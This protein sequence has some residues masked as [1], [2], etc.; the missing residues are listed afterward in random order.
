M[1]GGNPFGPDVFKHGSDDWAARKAYDEARAARHPAPA[2]SKTPFK[3]QPPSL[4][5]MASGVRG[6][7]SSAGGFGK[8]LAFVIVA[9]GFIAYFGSKSDSPRRT[10]PEDNVGYTRTSDPVPAPARTN[11]AI[12]GSVASGTA[13]TTETAPVDLPNPPGPR[14]PRNDQRVIAALNN[15]RTISGENFFVD[16]SFTALVLQGQRNNQ[17]QISQTS[18]NVAN[19]DLEATTYSDTDNKLTIPCKSES[20]CVEYALFDASTD[21]RNPS[22]KQRDRYGAMGIRANSREDSYR[23]LD[24]LQQLQTVARENGSQ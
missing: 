4:P 20:N 16:E 24:E 15:L 2:P 5:N 7:G 17:G 1:S 12:D 14:L 9:V 21:E 19:L 23:I 3:V 18:L 11:Q 10:L 8:F 6:G 13:D 22:L